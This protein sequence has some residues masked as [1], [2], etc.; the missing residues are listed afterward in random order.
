MYRVLFYVFLFGLVLAWLP[1]GN[2]MEVRKKNVGDDVQWKIQ[3]L[4]N[5]CGWECLLTFE[6]ESGLVKDKV[7]LK[8]NKNG[9]R[10]YG[11][12]QQNSQYHSDFIFGYSYKLRKQHW[13]NLTKVRQYALY[14]KGYK[15]KTQEQWM[16]ESR[17]ASDIM[18]HMSTFTA[19][20][21]DSKKQL[22][23]CIGIFQDAKK[24]GRLRT[25]FYAFNVINKRPGVRDRFYTLDK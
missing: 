7:S 16:M 10:D 4:Y 1:A 20:F 19:D 14:P 17:Q 12:C 24:K 9:T 2:A 11:Y 18:V 21:L 15:G 5:A 25:T 23:R 3:H 13:R 22:D 8:Q 6:A